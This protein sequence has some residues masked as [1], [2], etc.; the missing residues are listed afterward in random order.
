LLPADLAGE[1]VRRHSR[2]KVQTIEGCGHAP[3]LMNLEQIRSVANFLL[4]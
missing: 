1:M 2:A 3:P 4:S